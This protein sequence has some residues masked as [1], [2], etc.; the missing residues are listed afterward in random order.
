MQI[1]VS[2]SQLISGPGYNNQRA[3]AEITLTPEDIVLNGGYV[4]AFQWAWRQVRTE[5][6]KQLGIVTADDDQDIPF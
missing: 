2:Y 4:H 1:R 6:Q 5:V 3:E